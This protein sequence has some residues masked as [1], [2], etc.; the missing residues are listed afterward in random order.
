MGPRHPGRAAALSAALQIDAAEA[1]RRTGA[2]ALT[3][4]MRHRAWRLGN[5]SWL[6]H[7]GQKQA[8]ELVRSGR[9]RRYVFE[10]AR[11]WGKSW[12]F[13]VTAFECALAGPKRRI[14]Y[15]CST[16]TSLKEFIVPIMAKIIETAPD[17]IRPE[18]VGDVV[19]FKNG[20]R[21]VMQGCE[22]R[23]KAD[24]LR[25]PAADMAIVD[26][27]GFI[28]VLL[29][30]VKSVLLYQ[31]LTTRG[32]MLVGSSQPESPAHPFITLAQEAEKRGAHM[33]ASIM[34]APHLTD[35]DRAIACEESGGPESLSWKRE[36][37]NLRVVDVSRALVPEFSEHADVLVE[38]YE[39][40]R[41]ESG[42]VYVDRYIVGDLGWV[43]LAFIL[44]AEWD[45]AGS[46]LTVVDE[47]S[48]AR[49]TTD[50]LQHEVDDIARERWGDAPIY[51][52]II[53]ATARERA[54]LQRLQDDGDP[55]AENAWRMARNQERSAAVNQLRISTKRLRY[56]VHPRCT[57]L[58]AHLRNGV[59]N[60]QRTAFA[61]PA[62]DDG[63]TYYGHFDGVAAMMYLERAVDRSHNPTPPPKWDRYS[64][65]AP[66]V[67]NLPPGSDAARLQR[68]RQAFQRPR[69]T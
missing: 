31:L 46:M 55:T 9:S 12:F 51:R 66:S 68:T 24:R 36:G 59:W 38:A 65:I 13:C 67:A 33:A 5:L 32:L 58:I 60:E 20:S 53:D 61:R 1:E 6:L 64:Q 19:R 3:V 11:R 35:E 48:E 56:R 4:A 8:R 43:D 62:D 42:N 22:D 7:E 23:L 14:P 10:I 28:P 39:P 30:V 37:L 52:R 15:A 50:R 25:G 41:D 57:R 47:W 49:C 29:Y 54:D 44:F 69:K 17:D 21:I 45:F 2:A 34:D 27:A 26:E 40:R 63:E 18:I 16:I